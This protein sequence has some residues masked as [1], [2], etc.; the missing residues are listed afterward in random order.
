MNRKKDASQLLPAL[1]LVVFGVWPLGLWHAAALV[2]GLVWMFCIS[3][4]VTLRLADDVDLLE[5]KIVARLAEM[6]GGS[7]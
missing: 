7:P 6:K 3:E 4:E 1:A 5:E 2:G